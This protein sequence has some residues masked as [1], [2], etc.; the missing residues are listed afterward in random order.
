MDCEFAIAADA[1]PVEIDEGQFRQ[2]LN[3]LVINATQAM[4][5]GGTIEVKLENV[6]L[7]A[8]F[9]PP[10]PAGPYVKLSLKDHGEGIQP[11]NLPRIFEPYFTTKK[12][13]SGLGL[14]TAYSVV[15]KHEGQIRVESTPGAGTTFLIYLPAS[16]QKPV[17]RADSDQRDFF[18]QGRLLLM[19]DEPDILAVGSEMLR[20]YGY[21]VET[22]RDGAD[23][24]ARYIAAKD[25][26]QPFAAVIMDLTVPNGMGGRDAMRGLK[27]VDPDVKGI[28]SSGYSFDPVMGNYREYGF[29][30][31]IPKP[32][33]TEDLGRVLMEVLGSQPSTASRTN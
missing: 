11:E 28:V 25:A 5:G 18:G 29:C 32:Y 13:G 6:E 2:I 9:L 26:G 30:G 33:R 23:A 14:A 27:E 7:T 20:A 12:G 22:A 4:P 19:D 8:G 15:R 24:I 1:R 17:Q 31:I 16:V 21:D 3:H 10:L